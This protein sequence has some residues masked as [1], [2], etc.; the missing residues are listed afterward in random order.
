MVKYLFNIQMYINFVMLNKNNDMN[1]EIR[2]A[3]KYI[4]TKKMFVKNALSSYSKMMNLTGFNYEREINAL[5]DQLK[6]L[7]DLEKELEKRK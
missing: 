1:E 2:N 6:A 7:E 5:L 3:L 4:L